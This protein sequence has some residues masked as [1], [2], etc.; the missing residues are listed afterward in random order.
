MSACLK[1]IEFHVW[2]A[3]KCF[4]RDLLTSF[5]SGSELSR[6]VIISVKIWGIIYDIRNTIHQN[7]C[8][9]LPDCVYLE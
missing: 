2:Y 8:Y 5:D 4:I 1:Q 9:E 7:A 3:E 6:D